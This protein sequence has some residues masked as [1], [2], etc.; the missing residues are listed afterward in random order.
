MPAG[1]T[2]VM[3]HLAH[4]WLAG[5]DP[6]E[7][8]GVAM[9]DFWRGKVPDHWPTALREGVLWHR[10]V[11]A[12]TDQHDAVVAARNRFEPPFRRYAGILL[13]VWFDHVLAREFEYVA[14]VDLEQ[15]NR[16]V[17]AD[18]QQAQHA[19]AGQIDWP[20]HFPRFLAW[21]AQERVL[22]KYRDPTMIERTLAGLARRLSR[23]NPM[24]SAFPVLQARDDELRP[25]AIDVLRGLAQQGR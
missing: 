8:L 9:G 10:R 25:L 11:D 16:G 21:L 7:R 20:V 14:G 4:F 3:N 12:L 2:A 22:P 17:V 5:E 24:A 23:E 13:D 18:L 1:Y 15:F 19:L 6:I